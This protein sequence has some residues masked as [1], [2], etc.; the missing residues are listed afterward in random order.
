MLLT[1]TK[2][3][4]KQKRLGNKEAKREERLQN[5]S[6]ILTGADATDFRALAASANY[7]A[8][9]RPDISFSTKELCRYFS[10]PTTQSVEALR[11]LVRYLIGKKRLVWRY[12]FQPYTNKLSTYV[13]TDFGGCLVTRR[14]TSGG[15][16]MR[17]RH[18]IRHWSSTQ[19]TVALSSAEAEL[20][21]ICRGASQSI[22]LRSV[23]KDLNIDLT[24]E[25][26]TDATAAIGVC[27]RRGL[28]N[29]RH[30]ATADLWVQDKL[31]TQDFVLTKVDGSK[32]IADI[33]AK[34]VDRMTL[35]KHMM[36]MGLMID[37]G[38]ASSAPEIDHFQ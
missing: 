19:S 7:F 14:S 38:R 1:L 16:M 30:L 36:S 22:G 32:N 21:G 24:L 23:A 15:A 13:D 28:G 27:K 4:Y 8:L 31:R 18:L 11:R 17:G 5:P 26:L 20:T 37:W 35:E 10:T 3:K 12:D 25:I 33:L 34:I 9:D 29:I 2:K 6:P